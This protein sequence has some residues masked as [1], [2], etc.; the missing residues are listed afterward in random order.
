[1]YLELDI[2]TEIE[3]KSLCDLSKLKQLMENLKMKINKSQLARELGADRRTIDKY[4]NGFIPKETRKK[5]SKID[6]YYEDNCG[7]II[8]RIQTSLLLQTGFMAVLKR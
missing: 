1:M 2:Q 3:I 4:L 5:E 7:A 6:K 8:D